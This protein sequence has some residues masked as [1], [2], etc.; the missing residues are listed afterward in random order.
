MMIY[1]TGY[2]AIYGTW[3]LY[4]R[5]QMLF[6]R[7]AISMPRGRDRL[8]IAAQAKVVGEGIAI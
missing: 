2:P 1:V 7:A 3:P 5:G 6:V 8:L 4:F